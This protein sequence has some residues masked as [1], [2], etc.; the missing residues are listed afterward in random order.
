MDFKGHDGA[1]MLVLAT[2]LI[3]LAPIMILMVTR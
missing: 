2:F 3:M 1:V